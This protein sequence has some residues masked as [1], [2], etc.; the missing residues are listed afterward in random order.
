MIEKDKLP[1]KYLLDAEVL[2]KDSTQLYYMDETSRKLGE[3]QQ[4]SLIDMIL[5]KASP[6]LVTKATE[7]PEA[8][9]EGVPF[10]YCETNEPQVKKS[11]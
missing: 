1:A 10:Y 7:E 4:E 11:K 3:K 6:F 5:S 8:E 2:L 9:E